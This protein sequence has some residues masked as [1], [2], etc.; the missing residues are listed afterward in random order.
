MKLFPNQE[1]MLNTRLK[2]KREHEREQQSESETA[3]KKFL[4]QNIRDKTSHSSALGPMDFLAQCVGEVLAVHRAGHSRC[5][6]ADD[7]YSPLDSH[8]SKLRDQTQEQAA[9]NSEGVYTTSRHTEP[10]YRRKDL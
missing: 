6:A 1:L 9:C 3:R 4:Y 2:Q 5:S 8:P 10:A 7:M